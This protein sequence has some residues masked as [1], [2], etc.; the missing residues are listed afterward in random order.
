M[1]AK[2]LSTHKSFAIAALTEQIRNRTQRYFEAEEG[3]RCLTIKE[4]KAP[5]F[6]ILLLI[7]WDIK[8]ANGNSESRSSSYGAI[9]LMSPS[10]RYKSLV[11]GTFWGLAG[12]LLPKTALNGEL[13]G[14]VVS[15]KTMS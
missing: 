4:K 15:I 3:I 8:I 12:T 7:V 1:L 14:L 13:G 11:V 5:N 6:C 10:G 2:P 9:S